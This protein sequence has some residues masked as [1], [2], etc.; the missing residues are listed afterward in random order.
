MACNRIP[1]KER[2]WKKVDSSG[3]PEACWAW[4]GSTD[5]NGFGMVSI[6]TKGKPHAKGAAHRIAWELTNRAIPDGFIIIHTC[7]NTVCCNPRHLELKP[8]SYKKLSD[9]M[10]RFWSKASKGD[11]P[12]ACWIWTAGKD[13]HGYGL[14]SVWREGRGSKNERAHRYVY[15]VLIGPIPEGLAIL[16]SCDNPACVNVAHLRPGTLKENSEDMIAR[17]RHFAWTHPETMSRGEGSPLAKMTDAKVVEMRKMRRDTHASYKDLGKM[18]GV[19]NA[20]AMLI[21]RGESWAHV[22]ATEESPLAIN[23]PEKRRL[24]CTCDTCPTCKQRGYWRKWW[25]SKGKYTN[26]RSGDPLKK[27]VSISP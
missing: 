5:R 7:S 10:L 3:G 8:G 25:H 1:L 14:F 27:R 17:R 16:H 4:V 15:S 2:F 23:E 18:F 11:K 19:S 22:P 6:A 26:S 24:S 9:Q 13:A 12:D 21:C 20:A